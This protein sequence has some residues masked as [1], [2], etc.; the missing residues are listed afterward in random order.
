MSRKL[1]KS[2]L[3]CAAAA[4]IA[5]ARFAGVPH[6]ASAGAASHEVVASAVK[7]GPTTAPVIPVAVDS[8]FSEIRGHEGFW[9]IARTH[10]GIWWFLSPSGKTEF[11]NGVTTVQPSLASV[12]TDG[13]A[14]Y[15]SDWD[16]S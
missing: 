14:Y 7:P 11:L 3:F 16:R 15:S 10:D 4:V 6:E 13:A 9:R 5:T 2:I 8:R 1:V 12:Q